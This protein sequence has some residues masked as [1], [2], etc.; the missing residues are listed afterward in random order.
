MQA[1]ALITLQELT[2][3][4]DTSPVFEK[5]NLVFRAGERV[6][7]IGA[8]GSGKTTLLKAILGLIPKWDGTIHK[9]ENVRIGYL[10]QVLQ[11]AD[12]F[13]PMSV[14][15]VIQQGLLTNRP[16]PRFLTRKDRE[17]MN[18][19]VL[20][21]GLTPL[22]TQRFGFLSMG[23]KQLVLFV[24]M[25]LQKPDI[26]F[27][28][29]PTSSLDVS[30]KDSIYHMLEKLAKKQVAYVIIT[31]DLPSFNDSI[32]RVILLEHTI[33]FDGNHRDFCENE[34]FSPFIHTHGSSDH[35]HL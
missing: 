29:E 9:A 32:D 4:Y 18:E 15:E 21:T 16:F 27:L 2:V 30:R 3:G 28:D 14:K 6:A 22:L 31:H 1:K 26:V 11:I 25:L 8:N 12:R 24:R 13:F 20:Q 5:L 19:M 23:Q 35:E 17:D 7:L 10:P 33:L 34:A